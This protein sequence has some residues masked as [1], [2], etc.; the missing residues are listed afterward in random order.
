[1]KLQTID[2]H[3]AVETSYTAA[4]AA[5][6]AAERA[7]C[8]LHTCVLAANRAERYGNELLTAA[9]TAAETA[10]I[11]AIITAAQF[12]SA[13][14]NIGGDKDAAAAAMLRAIYSARTALP[15]FMV[16]EFIR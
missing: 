16:S 11:N 10:A 6:N 5:Y 12:V 8:G 13:S 9:E 4:R 7:A 2:G 1:M 15:G 14:Y 3:N